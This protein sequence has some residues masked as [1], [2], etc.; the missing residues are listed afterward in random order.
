MTFKTLGKTPLDLKISR[1]V[2]LAHSHLYSS[3]GKMTGEVI[4][5]VAKITPHFY[6]SIHI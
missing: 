5:E 2:Q 1:T 4:V 3:N 6:I